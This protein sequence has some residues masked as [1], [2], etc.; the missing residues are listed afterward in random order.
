[1]LC[2][3]SI[4]KNDDQSRQQGGTI[5]GR[6]EEPPPAEELEELTVYCFKAGKADATLIYSPKLTILIDCGEKGFGKE[7]VSYLKAHSVKKLDM[8]IITHFDKD[9]VGG[10]AKVIKELD[11]AQV[12]QSNCPKESD[13]Y[14]DYAEALGKKNIKPV[15]IRERQS[16]RIG[17]AEI[18]VYPPMQEYYRTDPSNNSSLITSVGYGSN[19]LLFAADAQDAR[20]MEFAEQNEGTFDFLK[21][22]YHGHYQQKLGLFLQSVSPRIAVITSSDEEPEDGKTM[23]LLSD[24]NAKVF[25]TRTAPVIIRCDGSRITAEYEM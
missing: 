5:T 18:T 8:L 25:L 11:I 2:A 4:N 19:R 3:C 16:V 21:V 13:A 15:T 9:H 23:Q 24:I 14:D 12:V 1:M 22:P 20:L 17:G 7:I 10:A 6:E